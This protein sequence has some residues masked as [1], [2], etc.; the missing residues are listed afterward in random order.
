MFFLPYSIV[1]TV[2][3]WNETT[4]RIPGFGAYVFHKSYWLITAT[5]GHLPSCVSYLRLSY[6][7]QFLWHYDIHF[8]VCILCFWFSICSWFV[9]L[10][11]TCSRFVSPARWLCCW[12]Y[13]QCSLPLYYVDGMNLMIHFYHRAKR[14]WVTMY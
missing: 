14:K 10:C 12:R 3:H 5:P 8:I 7:W 9:S 1:S 6:I 4:I 11:S 13:F 2:N